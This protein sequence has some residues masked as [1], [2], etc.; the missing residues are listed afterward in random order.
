MKK[1]EVDEDDREQ[2]E[3]TEVEAVEIEPIG[4]GNECFCHL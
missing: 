2:E 4:R 1:A 3:D